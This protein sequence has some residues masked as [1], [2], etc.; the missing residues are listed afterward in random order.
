MLQLTLSYFCYC[1]D[2]KTFDF[3]TFLH[4]LITYKLHNISNANIL[5]FVM[6]MYLC[7][8]KYLQYCTNGFATLGRCYND[9]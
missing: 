6:E 5:N 8:F 1:S 9:M 7:I 3:F 4:F 2:L